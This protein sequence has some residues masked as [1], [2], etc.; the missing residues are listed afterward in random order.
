MPNSVQTIL[1]LSK[2]FLVYQSMKIVSKLLFFQ[3]FFILKAL[4]ENFPIMKKHRNLSE[5]ITYFRY[6]MLWKAKL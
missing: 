2:S 4:E 5:Y 1:I 3:I 6:L